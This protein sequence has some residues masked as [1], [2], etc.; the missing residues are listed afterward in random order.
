MGGHPK[1]LLPAPQPD[2]PPEPAQPLTL[3]ERLATL[4]QAQGLP[5]V[6]VGQHSD[7]AGLGLPLLADQPPAADRWV[8]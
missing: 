5:V 4:A 6:L 2:Q 8:A 3:V 7:Y 1:G